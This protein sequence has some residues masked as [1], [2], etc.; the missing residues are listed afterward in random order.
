[1][2]KGL[3]VITG[4]SAGFGQA[5]ALAFAKLGYS[6]A[7]GARRVEKLRAVAQACEKAGA[8]RAQ[9]IA[10]DVTSLPSIEQFARSAGTPDILVNNA[11]V[12]KGRDSIDKLHD[13]DIVAMVETNI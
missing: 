7:L 9:A 1:M 2:S 13:E 10:L 5:T 3:V 4:A 6:L 12:A 11:G 8:P